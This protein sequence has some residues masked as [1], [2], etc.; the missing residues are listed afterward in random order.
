MNTH[1]DSNIDDCKIVQR[2]VCNK[3][4]LHITSL[5]VLAVWLIRLI[6]TLN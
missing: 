4:D 3:H 2:E 1:D 5:Y 6:V